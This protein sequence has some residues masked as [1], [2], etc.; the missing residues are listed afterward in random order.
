HGLQAD[1]RYQIVQGSGAAKLWAPPKRSVRLV[2]SR[3]QGP[4]RKG[5]ERMP[6]AARAP[7]PILQY[8]DFEK[9]HHTLQE[10]SGNPMLINLWA[11]WCSPCAGELQE[12][13]QWAPQ[14][15]AG[16]LEIIA[17]SVDGL[18]DDG[19]SEEAAG[20]F[21][22]R[23]DF[24][25]TWGLAN[26]ML[27]DK[28]EILQNRLFDVRRPFSLPSSFLVDARGE[29]ATIYRGPVRMGDLLADLKSLEDG[30]DE[31]RRTAA[32]FPG[33]WATQAPRLS[34]GS[35]AMGF[36]E[37]DLL[38]DA[39]FYLAQS[40]RILAAEPE[41]SDPSYVEASNN[42]GV[43]LAKQGR[44][45]EAVVH[46]QEAL[47]IDP[48]SVRAHSN[49]GAALASRG[50]LKKAIPHFR[51]ALK[52]KPD[53]PELRSNLGAALF[54]RGLL[55]QAAAQLRRVLETHPGM[56]KTQYILGLV[57]ARQGKTAEATTH[58]RKALEIAASE[59]ESDL[60][61]QI[62]RELRFL[63]TDLP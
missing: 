39:A 62:R 25:F 28:L 36:L 44:L 47:R 16:G 19:S 26:P 31:R 1:R 61:V 50:K 51:R 48:A 4:D 20:E 2:P 53:D 32:P 21:R 29:L 5:S 10:R 55:D 9:R 60:A 24:P 41:L 13:A 6:L 30:L 17:L 34:L 37:D 54:S 45:K 49:L 46:Y 33:R 63:E 15:R 11:S 35:I 8:T 3:L 38:E 7:L 23:F 59:P 14:L 22:A 40:Q 12:L 18:G 57:L 42:L 58:L 56:A 27:L 52:I 43:E